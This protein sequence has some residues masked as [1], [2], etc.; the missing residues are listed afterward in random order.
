VLAALTAALLP[1][2]GAGAQRAAAESDVTVVDVDVTPSADDLADGFS[3]LTVDLSLT[4]SAPL[5]DTLAE[6][7]VGESFVV[8]AQPASGSRTW[9]GPGE[10]VPDHL[11][12][13]DLQRVAG[14]STA[15]TWRATVEVSPAWSGT[16]LVTDV[17]DVGTPTVGDS[18]DVSDRGLLLD[19][20]AV[21]PGW[22][23]V[24]APAPVKVVTGTEPWVPRARVT[25]RATGAGIAA[26]WLDYNFYAEPTLSPAPRMPAAARLPRADGSGYLALSPR[27]VVFQDGEQS[28][29]VIHVYA[30]RGSRGYSWEAGTVL[31]P[32]VKWQANQRFST[33]GRTV[34]ASGNAWPAPAVYPAAN[35]TVRLQ[36]L[37][38]RTWRTV[39]S[40]T[41]R[42]N[43]RYTIVWTAPTAGQQVVRVYKPGGA[44]PGP[45]HLTSTG[46]T[47]AAAT[48]TTS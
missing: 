38:G 20:G 11:G 35:P 36:Q 6:G 46:S 27:P 32:Q 22:K 41:V 8:R 26:A 1:G 5:P 19:L 10:A 16:W 18:I 42:S 33:S 14:T 3:V 44:T 21:A 29:N 9:V 4:S 47:L 28:R 2:A 13:T 17:A 25:D 48:V 34:T 15:G 30:G 45:V 37:V 40:A 7:V 23:A 43:G 31:W 12:W 39:A 24:P